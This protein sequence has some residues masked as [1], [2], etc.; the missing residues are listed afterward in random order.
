MLFNRAMIHF[1]AY[2]KLLK[3]EMIRLRIIKNKIDKRSVGKKN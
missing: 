2:A 3:I 1:A